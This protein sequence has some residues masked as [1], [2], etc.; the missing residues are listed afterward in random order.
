MFATKLEIF[1]ANIQSKNVKFLVAE[2]EKSKLSAL[3]DTN[4]REMLE[5]AE[6]CSTR[7]L[8]AEQS[9]YGRQFTDFFKI[10]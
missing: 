1:D 6:P 2:P 8:D 7:L 9:R 3:D 5:L 4:R 10:D